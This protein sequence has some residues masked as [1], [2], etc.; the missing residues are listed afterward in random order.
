[1]DGTRSELLL[2]STDEALKKAV[3][4]AAGE[5][6][7]CS[8][9]HA[10]VWNEALAN[11]SDPELAVLI[12]HVSPGDS[13]R[14]VHAII[15]DL[16]F[17]QREVATLII[18]ESEDVE[19]TLEFLRH[20]A[21]QVLTRPLN[22]NNLS[23]LI[24]RLTLRRRLERKD[25]IGGVHKSVPNHAPTEDL[26]GTPS[27]A[28]APIVEK[29]RQLMDCDSNLVI[30]GET[31]VGKSH[32]ARLIHHSSQRRD[33]PFVIVSCAALTQN[34]VESELF[35]HKKGAFTSSV[36]D[37]QGAFH[38]AADGTLVLEDVDTLP[39]E[40]QPKL[41][42]V[43][44]NREFHP[45][46]SDKTLPFR[47]RLIATSNRPL[48]ED[49]AKG[50]FRADLYYRLKVSQIRFPPLRERRHEIPSLINHVLKQF[51]A[52]YKREELVLSP[53][54]TEVLEAY[55]WPGNIRELCNAIEEAAIQSKGNVIQLS[56]LPD[57]IQLATA[58]ASNSLTPTESPTD[59]H[60]IESATATFQ[61]GQTM[62][63]I[64]LS[65]L[66]FEH[67]KKQRLQVEQILREENYNRSL[68][69]R[70]MNLSRAGFY[71]LLHRLD[72]V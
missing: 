32:F 68:A 24:D 28:M 27:A 46:G 23:W 6:G 17:F 14:E 71:K 63:G 12:V 61:T 10:R 50:S 39:L 7:G 21:T 45:V 44:D 3:G 57:A 52:K 59:T 67:R 72:M 47:A 22:L 64:T 42:Q 62:H 33:K 16:A 11:L 29:M 49:V 53:E 56:D 5:V 1:M 69:A 30:L 55:R 34:L 4:A 41:L 26:F 8:L 20:G 38:Q 54:A 40:I 66:D 70:R 18:E 31:G 58:V 37:R 48:A 60:E 43:L 13:C 19:Q 36:S 51:D 65:E 2:V 9:L 15:D 25:A 35:G